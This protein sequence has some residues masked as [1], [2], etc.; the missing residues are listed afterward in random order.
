MKIADE[1]VK[2][3]RRGIRE[4]LEGRYAHSESYGGSERRHLPRWPFPGPVEI[5]PV[6][7]DGRTR[8]LGTSRDISESGMGMSCDTHFDPGT[9]LEIALHLPEATFCGK[10]LVRYCAESR[11]GF[12]IG[13]EFEFEE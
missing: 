10:G 3:T 13:V 4:L 1:I 2:L 9:C 6:D 12:M 5:W 8:W 11:H 7:G